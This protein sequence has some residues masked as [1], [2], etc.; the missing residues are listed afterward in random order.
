MNLLQPNANEATQTMNRSR[1]VSP[2]SGICTRCIDGCRG[3][4]EVFKS[5][6]RG[7]EVHLPGSLRDADRRRRQEL[8]GRLFAPEHRR[9]RPG[10]QGSAR[11]RGGAL[12][13]HAVPDGQHG[14]GVRRQQEGEDAPADLHRRSGLHRDR[15]QELGALRR[16]RRDLGHH[17]RLRRERLRHRPGAG[18]GRQG[19]GDEVPEHGRPRRPS[20]GAITKATAT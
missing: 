16:R 13:Q 11:R 7:R 17:A 9:L 15:P 2:V 10:R 20:T 8:P 4:C 5:T 12:G 14:D 19:Q 18:A 6:F 3:N 1:S